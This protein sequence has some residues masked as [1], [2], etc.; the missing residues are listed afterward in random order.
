MRVIRDPDRV[1]LDQPT[2][3]TVGAF[4]GLHLGH[5]ELLAQ[6]VRRARDTKRT[7]VVLTFDPLPREVLHPEGNTTCLMTIDDKLQLLGQWGLDVAVV[8]PFTGELA[9]TTARDFV[10]MLHGHLQMTELWVGWDF[11][12]G[13]E[14]SGSVST[15]GKLGKTL[16]FEV[17][18]VE[19]VREGGVVIS[20][21]EIRRLIAAGRV[22]EAAEMLGR[23]HELR[24]QVVHGDGRGRKL[25]FPTANLDVREHCA[26]PANGVYAV[27]ATVGGAKYRAVA[28]VGLRPTFGPGERAI[29]VHLLDFQGL[30]YGQEMTVQFVERLRSERRFGNQEAL[31]AQIAADIR[32]ARAV[33][34]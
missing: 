18:V 11:A 13:R 3:V 1:H 34:Q 12:L 32:H 26:I 25:G 17:R 33:L 19:P 30:F 31:C 9:S 10:R 16:G 21:T 23:Y 14:R 5:H 2:V 7:S 20:S 4:D 27:Y 29:E 22:G 8:L 6:L 24:G 15:L 28:N